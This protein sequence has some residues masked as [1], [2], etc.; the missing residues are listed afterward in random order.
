M[1][2]EKINISTDLIWRFLAF[3]QKF[4]TTKFPQLR[5][6]KNVYNFQQFNL[7]ENETHNRTSEN[8]AN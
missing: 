5:Y 6:I 1:H 4:S 2:Q 8:K 7:L 3:V